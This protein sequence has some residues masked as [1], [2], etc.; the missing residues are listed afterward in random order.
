MADI[1]AFRALRYDL[2][3]AGDIGELTCAPY[4]IISEDQRQDYLKR[5]PY[6]IV[7][8]ELPKGD[9]PYTQAGKT[10][11]SWIENGI[12]KLDMDPGL[13]IYE[14]ELLTKVDSGET[15]KLRT[16]ICRVRL[17]EFAAGVVLPH[18]ETLS[19]AKQDRFDLMCATY[20]NFSQIYSL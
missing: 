4:D 1:K 19:K 10:L 6:N 20:C 5:N 3:K 7:R 2:P 16:L 13:Y 12:L 11:H 8:L 9:D 14:M 17:E 18:E 15:K